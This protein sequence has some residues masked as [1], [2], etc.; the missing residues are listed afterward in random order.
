MRF[1]A[2]RGTRDILPGEA[3]KW[4]YIEGK[5]REIM[6]RYNYQEIRTPSF[7]ATEL[8]ARGIG[9]STDIVAKEMYT[10]T[11]R[12]ARS[13]TLRP[14]GTA[15][16]IRAYVEHNLGAKSLLSKLFYIAPMFRYEKPQAG[17]HREHHQFGAE[18]IGTNDPAQDAELIALLI[19]ILNELG[20]KTP[21]LLLNSL[22]CPKCRPA[23]EE[24]LR[25]H[26]QGRLELL[27]GD[28]QARH[29][30]NPLRILDC[31]REGCRQATENVPLMFDHLCQDCAQHFDKVKGYLDRLEIDYVLEGRLVRGLD[32]YTRTMFE[33]I[34]D[35][36][37][38][39]D[40]LGGG[41]RYDGLVEEVGGKPTPAVGFAAGLERLMIVLEKRKAPFPEPK[42]VD[43]FVASLGDR[44]KGMVV[45]MLKEARL[46]GISCEM[47]YLGRSLKAQMREA[48]RMGVKFVL[49]VGED[50][51]RTGK[52]LL[53][54]MDSGQQEELPLEG[55][56]DQ[57]VARIVS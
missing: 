24:E 17:R 6:G 18:S 42:G 37:G 53:R 3:E 32:Y 28:C 21:I 9:E 55:L 39:Q 50:E 31:K 30:S 47:D 33:V 41:G 38:A 29:W 40:A 7:E 20:L 1:K 2:L 45:R 14:E 35:E 57:L 49:I 46:A 25:V 11:D 34:S 26:L 51:L 15:P 56:M 22:G 4:Q 12:G 52:A 10:F 23:Y 48:N 54:N 19:H 13:L 27:C 36:L 8:F 5:I 44:A 43:L 16:V